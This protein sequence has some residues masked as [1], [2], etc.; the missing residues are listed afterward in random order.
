MSSGSQEKGQP[1]TIGISGSTP[2]RARTAVDLAVPFSPRI[3]TPPMRGFIA[4]RTRDNFI[5]SC[6]TIAVKGKWYVGMIALSF[7]ALLQYVI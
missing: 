6:P 3:S 7:A 2:A 1:L 5:C 4:F